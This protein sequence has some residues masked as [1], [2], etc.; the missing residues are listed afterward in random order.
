[1]LGAVGV[2]TLP[3]GLDSTSIIVYYYVGVNQRKEKFYENATVRLAKMARVV[4]AGIASTYCC[5]CLI[6]NKLNQ[7]KETIRSG[8]FFFT[9]W[10]NFRR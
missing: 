10:V 8:S 5:Q 7:S 1:M 6:G 2:Y 3:V 4:L 9:Y